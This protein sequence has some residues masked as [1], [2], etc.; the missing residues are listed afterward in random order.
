MQNR[1]PLEFKKRSEL[2]ELWREGPFAIWFECP[3]QTKEV[4]DRMERLGNRDYLRELGLT[5]TERA[6]LGGRS[7]QSP[8]GRRGPRGRR[9]PPQ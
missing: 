2:K 3:I 8:P 5:I 6:L 1:A 7:K 4:A 9:G